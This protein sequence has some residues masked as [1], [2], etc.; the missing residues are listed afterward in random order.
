MASQKRMP[1]LSERSPPITL[2][3]AIPPEEDNGVLDSDYQ[4]QAEHCAEAQ[5]EPDRMSD[6]SHVCPSVRPERSLRHAQAEAYALRRPL[7]P[8]TWHV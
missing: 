6:K 7:T 3:T 2:Q 1:Y 4:P 8:P 5:H